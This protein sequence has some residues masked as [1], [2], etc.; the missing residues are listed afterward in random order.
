MKRFDILKTIQLLVF[1]AVAGICIATLIFDDSIYNTIVSNKRMVLLVM[2]LWAALFFSFFFIFLDFSMIAKQ[3]KNFNL[4][5]YSAH[6][7]P[8][9]KIANRNGVDELIDKYADLPLPE[10]AGCIMFELTS[11]FA[12]NR[13]YSRSEGNKQIRMFSII[14]KMASVDM[15]FVGRNGGN[16]FLALFE[17]GGEEAMN[18]FLE[19]V[20]EKVDE[21]NE[22]DGNIEMTYQYG[23][24]TYEP[25]MKEISNLVSISS[26][27]LDAKKEEVGN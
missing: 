16:R 1:V 23:T 3:K 10:D 15:C 18:Q 5:D 12:V 25:D 14:I 17:E 9:A 21:Y 20:K 27:R 22:T 7:D 6:S 2:L 4:L 11:L 26:R 13:D 19:R 8:L 24:A